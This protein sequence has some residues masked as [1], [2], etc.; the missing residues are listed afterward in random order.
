MTR[1]LR[2]CADGIEARFRVTEVT[3]SPVQRVWRLK[4]TGDPLKELEADNVRFQ[5]DLLRRENL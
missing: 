4:G 5:I 3:L 1:P 2:R